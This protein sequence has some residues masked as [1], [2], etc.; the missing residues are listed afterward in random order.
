MSLAVYCVFIMAAADGGNRAVG[1]EE[2]REA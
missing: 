2:G 1:R